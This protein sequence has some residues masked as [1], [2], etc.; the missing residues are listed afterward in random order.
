M[1]SGKDLGQS[2]KV[3][4]THKDNKE[5]SA[6]LHIERL[7]TALFNI[8]SAITAHQDLDKTL[9]VIVQESLNCLKA[10][11]STIFLIDPKSGNLKP[12]FTQALDA[13]DERVGL[14][15]EREVAQKT[16]ELKK[17]FLVGGRGKSS[18]LPKGQKHERKIITILTLADHL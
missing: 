14:F 4:L 1:V 2:P 17:P 8:S 13:L 15:E 16:F 12:Q 9:E 11:R 3:G 6:L 18:D 10:N 7:E 5:T